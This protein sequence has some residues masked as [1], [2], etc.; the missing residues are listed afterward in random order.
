M[1]ATGGDI[2]IS[3]VNN[4]FR[5]ISGGDPN[6]AAAS[7]VAAA[8]SQPLLQG[9]GR[10]I[11]LEDLTQAERDMVYAIRNSSATGKVTRSESPKVTLTL[12]AF[13]TA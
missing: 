11:A 13:K 4:L 6:Q 8:V 7:A 5:V 3:L 12:C 2:S 9:A 1:L 10:R